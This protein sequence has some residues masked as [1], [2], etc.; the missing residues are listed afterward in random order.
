MVEDGDDG[1]V[2][3]IEPQLSIGD[4][5]DSRLLICLNGIPDPDTFDEF[6][7]R[8]NWGDESMLSLTPTGGQDCPYYWTQCARCRYVDAEFTGRAA[9]LACGHGVGDKD[10]RAGSPPILAAYTLARRAVPARWPGASCLT[11]DTS[12]ERGDLI[13]SV[14]KKWQHARCAHTVLA[15]R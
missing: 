1:L 12:V 3:L 2:D 4:P 11:C 10:Y 9:R 7:P 15:A 8:E 14:D 5:S 13:V 6:G